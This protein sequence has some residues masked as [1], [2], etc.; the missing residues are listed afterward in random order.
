[1]QSGN[2]LQYTPSCHSE[3]C[4]EAHVGAASDLSRAKEGPPP[5]HLMPAPKGH[6]FLRSEALDMGW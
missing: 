2:I 4:E 5:G 3:W 6:F 1:M